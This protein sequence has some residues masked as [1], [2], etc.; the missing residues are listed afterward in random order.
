MFTAKHAFLLRKSFVLH[1]LEGPNLG[2]TTESTGQ[3]SNPRP[4]ELLLS[5]LVPVMTKVHNIFFQKES[6]Q[7]PVRQQVGP[8][9]RDPRGR[10]RDR[11]ELRRGQRDGLHRGLR[12][13]R[14]KRR[15]VLPDFGRVPVKK[16]P[17]K[18]SRKSR[19]RNYHRDFGVHGNEQISARGTN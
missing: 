7:V 14:N 4:L 5:S 17:E 3:E 19:R 1:L 8:R 6:S 10:V 13:V 11:P 18:G 2:P 15:P 9:Q 12:Q 16:V